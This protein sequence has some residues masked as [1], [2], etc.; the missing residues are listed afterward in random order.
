MH[1]IIPDW[2]RW[3]VPILGILSIL[4]FVPSLIYF[5]R[6]N[7]HQDYSKVP[8]LTPAQYTAEVKAIVAATYAAPTEDPADYYRTAIRAQNFNV[9]EE[10]FRRDHPAEW[11]RLAH[12]RS[13]SMTFNVGLLMNEYEQKFGHSTM[14]DTADRMRPWMNEQIGSISAPPDQVRLDKAGW[15]FVRGYIMCVLLSVLFYM[16][17]LKQ[18]GMLIWPEMTT[19]FLFLAA[20]TGLGVVMIYPRN[21]DPIV[22]IKRA[23][24]F[25]AG[26]AAGSIS[27]AGM[28]GM[29]NARERL[30]SSAAE[31]AKVFIL[32]FVPMPEFSFSS[33]VMS[34]KVTGNGT[35]VNDGITYTGGVHAA[36]AGGVDLDLSG[37]RQATGN[38]SDEID[39]TISKTM[40]GKAGSVTAGF[41][42]FDIVPVGRSKG[43]DMISPFISLEHKL[44]YGLTAFAKADGYFLTHGPPT[45]N[46]FDVIAGLK[47]STQVRSLRFDHSVS[48]VLSDGPFGQSAGTTLRFD[49]A[50]SVP[51][52]KRLRASTNFKLFVPIQGSKGREMDVSGGLG[53][54][55]AF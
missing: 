47:G 54:N 4:V 30:E 25:I 39:Y 18:E 12:K 1:R 23:W 36:F 17:R 40:K 38:A 44:G 24:R 31:N 51:V 13:A 55:Y 6:A 19:G 50:I 45:N 28:A 37:T 27:L 43:G 32:P 11:Q 14:V 48:A 9:M 20:F 49:E 16:A 8:A 2:T 15:W 3:A 10:R 21:I 52:T 41:A 34:S 42:Y 7:D 29:A 53:L 33:G 5:S 46:G 35:R 26:L 22:Q